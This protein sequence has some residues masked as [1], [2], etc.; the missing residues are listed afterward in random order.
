MLRLHVPA[1]VLASRRDLIRVQ[2]SLPLG[3]YART[4]IA[5]A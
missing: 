2:L 5:L 1:D 4:L 3:R